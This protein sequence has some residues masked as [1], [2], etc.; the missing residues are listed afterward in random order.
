MSKSK[1]KTAHRALAGEAL[2]L[3]AT[4]F[5]VLGEASR[6][7]LIQALNGNERSVNDL[8]QATGLTQANA[9]RHLQTLTDAGVLKR[10]K[11][12][13]QVF[14][15]VA[16]K[17]IFNLCEHVCGSLQERIEAHAKALGG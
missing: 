2:E 16:D 17:N 7:K 3:V 9:S 8:T 12:G 15:S 6:L 11:Q 1:S 4:R 14:Y 10:R 13:L 5:R